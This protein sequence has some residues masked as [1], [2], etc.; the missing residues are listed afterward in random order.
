V[1]ENPPGN[2][3]WISAITTDTSSFKVLCLV[4][5]MA[6][7]ETARQ[8]REYMNSL[9]KVNLLISNELGMKKMPQNAL[10][11]SLSIPDEHDRD[12]QV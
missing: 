3:A 12:Q 2:R 10:T 6:D 9:G 5:E 4:I 1:L 8:R 7:F 11:I